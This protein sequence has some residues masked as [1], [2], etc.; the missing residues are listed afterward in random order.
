MDAT[1]ALIVRILGNALELPYCRTDSV[2][3]RGGDAV[4]DQRYRSRLNRLSR[5]VLEAKVKMYM[6]VARAEMDLF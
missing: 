2:L 6:F 5:S 4:L 3:F 1:S